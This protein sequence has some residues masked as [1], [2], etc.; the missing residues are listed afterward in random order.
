[1]RRQGKK[2]A[3]V[4]RIQARGQLHIPKY[5]RP[6]APEP[7]FAEALAAFGLQQVADAPASDNDPAIASA[8]RQSTPGAKCYLWPCNLPTFNC[9][10]RLQTQWRVGGMGSRTGLDY[11]AVIRYMHDVLRIKPK[12]FAEMFRS[13]QAM[14]IAALEVWSEQKN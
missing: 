14:E 12:V 6:D 2:L 13:L 9:W 1:M 3:Q 11:T 10:Q 5:G 4:A 8:A 7:D